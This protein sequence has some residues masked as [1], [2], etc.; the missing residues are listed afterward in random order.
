MRICKRCQWTK[1]MLDKE[2]LKLEDYIA[3]IP[4]DEKT[5]DTEY[6][7]RLLLCDS[8]EFMRDGL[9]GRGGCS[10]ALRAAKKRQYCPDVHKK[11]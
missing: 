5:D 8:C 2:L 10:V 7:R 3:R 1:E 6:E 4:E 11:W 9:C